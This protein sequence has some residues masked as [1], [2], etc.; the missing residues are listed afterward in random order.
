MRSIS[1]KAFV[2]KVFICSTLWI[3]GCQTPLSESTQSLKIGMEKSEVLEVL[4]SP[5]QTRRIRGQDQWSYFYFQEAK[6]RYQTDLMFRERR[7]VSMNSIPPLSPTELLLNESQTLEE[8][9]SR[10]RKARESQAHQP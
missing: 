2:G 7:L 4:G 3:L 5:H 1:V 8:Y 10:V 6:G 9:E